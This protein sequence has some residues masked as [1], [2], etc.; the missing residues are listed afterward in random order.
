MTHDIE[1][2]DATEIHIRPGGRKLLVSLEGID[3][4]DLYA[5]MPDE[6]MDELIRLAGEERCKA[7]IGAEVR[8]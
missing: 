6:L 8:L 5:Q 2:L 1:A 3:A 4:A 7:A